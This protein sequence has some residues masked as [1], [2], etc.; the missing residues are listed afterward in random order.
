MVAGFD[1]DMM[2]GMSAHIDAEDTIL[3]GRVTHQ[4]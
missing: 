4:D 1:N 2:A 3:M